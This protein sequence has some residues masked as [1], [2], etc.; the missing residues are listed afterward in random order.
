[1][2]HHSFDLNEVKTTTTTTWAYCFLFAREKLVAQCRN[3]NTEELPDEFVYFLKLLVSHY[4][5]EKHESG[6]FNTIRSTTLPQNISSNS[7]TTTTSTITSGTATTVTTTALPNNVSPSSSNSAT[8]TTS[9]SHQSSLAYV[10]DAN[11]SSTPFKIREKSASSVTVVSSDSSIS[12][13]SNPLSNNLTHHLITSLPHDIQPSLPQNNNRPSN[14]LLIPNKQQQQSIADILN[15]DDTCAVNNMSFLSSSVPSETTQQTHKTNYHPFHP[16]NDR[17]ASAPSSPTHRSRSQ[18]LSSNTNNEDSS[19]KHILANLINGETS[20][21]DQT[22]DVKL[23]RRWIKSDGHVY[24]ANFIIILL[25]DGLCSI[26]VCKDDPD[27][28]KPV[29]SKSPWKPMS[30]Q[31]KLFKSQLRSSLSDFTTFIL[32][33]EATHFTNLSFAVT[34]PG[35][36]HFVHLDRGVMVSP[37]LVDLNELDKNHELL[38]E[39]YGRYY[40]TTCTDEGKWKWPTET[41]LKKL[42]NQML[43]LGISFRLDTTRT[44]AIKESSNSQYYFLYQKGPHPHQELLAIYFSIVPPD[45]LW[46][47]H[48]KLLNDICQRTLSTSSSSL[49][50]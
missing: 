28:N 29:P 23:V 41:N 6:I 8:T 17:I 4:L 15:I 1:N 3:S 47:M 31:V 11:S 9:S 12:Y 30:S 46:S 44:K 21:L 37:R 7:T 33:K 38:H 5:Q 34:Y 14:V 26:V 39:V 50:L 49:S 48:Q 19:L 18:S 43:Q 24:L 10:Y 2:K 42:C 22:E 45:R 25:S 40:N 20:Y 35:L 36:I 16:D 27:K 13:W 32:T